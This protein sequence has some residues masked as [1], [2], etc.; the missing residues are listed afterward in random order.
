VNV[1]RDPSPERSL[2][3]LVAEQPRRAQ[4]F[5]QL[6]LDYC[7]GGRQTLAEACAKRGLDLDTVR[8]ALQ[9]LDAPDRG[10]D[11]ESTDWRA[12]G[13]SELCEHIVA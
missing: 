11:I 3:T 1:P 5:E 12:I 2:G 10:T 9:A 4:L 13:V 6:R 7:C 8:A